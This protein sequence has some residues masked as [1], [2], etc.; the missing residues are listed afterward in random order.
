VFAPG[1]APT[2]DEPTTAS[3]VQQAAAAGASQALVLRLTHLGSSTRVRLTVYAAGSGQIVY[4]DSIAITGGPGDLDVVLQRLVHA[5]IEGK[6]VR[7]SAELETVTNDEMNTLNRRVANKSFGVHLFAML[8]FNTPDGK[9]RTVP[10]FGLFWMYDAR[11]WIAD[12]ALDLGGH[13]AGNIFD[14]A[15]GGYY[16]LTRNDF[17]PYVGA[18]VKFAHVSFGG[19]GSNGLILQPTAGL[20]L[21][22]TSS[23]QMRAELGYFIDSFAEANSTDGSEHLSHG[24][25]FNVGLGF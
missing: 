15:L 7:D 5:M 22:R 13:G 12:V 19:T 3:A 14:I 6:P 8:P 9:T 23:V 2:T 17:A 10:G 4:W 24:I 11:S 18:T 21:G 16:P 20:L 1:G 25:S